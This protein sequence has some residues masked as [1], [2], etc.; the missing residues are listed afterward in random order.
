LNYKQHFQFLH[1]PEQFSKYFSAR[2][3]AVAALK[4]GSNLRA[5]FGE[6]RKFQNGFLKKPCFK[7]FIEVLK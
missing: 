7:A 6:L 1:C 2:K 3:A 5:C 4:T